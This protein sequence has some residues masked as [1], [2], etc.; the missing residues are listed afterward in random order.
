MRRFIDDDSGY[1]D[2]LAANPQGYVINAAR[3]PASADLVLH[4]AR[5]GTIGGRP[6]RGDRWTG[7]YVKYCGERAELEAFARDHLAGD[8]QPCGLCLRESAA[9]RKSPAAHAR[10]AAPPPGR[11]G[12][13]RPSGAGVGPLSAALAAA[14]AG[15]RPPVLFAMPGS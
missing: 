1:L 11:P 9:R 3:N 5:C 10:P 15:A 6:A 4:R 7:D 8:P 13:D 2:W 14:V 12:A